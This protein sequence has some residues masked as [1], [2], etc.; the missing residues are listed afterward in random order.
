M[1]D[2]SLSLYF[3]LQ[4]QKKDLQQRLFK[5]LNTFASKEFF[6]EKAMVVLGVFKDKASV[7]MS[8]DSIIKE[9]KAT[10][11]G[12]SDLFGVIFPTRITFPL[13]IAQTN[14]LR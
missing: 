11:S 1:K 13:A 9:V 8:E 5:A 14:K 6:E 10:S 12:Y 2:D 3:S 4:L 7:Y